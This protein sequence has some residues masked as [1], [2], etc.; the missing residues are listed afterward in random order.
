MIDRTQILL[1][2]IEIS[3]EALSQIQLMIEHDVTIENK[4]LRLQISGKGC[5]GFDYSMGFIDRL[6]DDL[7]VETHGL[8]FHFD[9]FSAYYMSQVRLEYFRDEGDAEGFVITN[10][11]QDKFQ[12]KFWRKAPDLLPPEAP[13]V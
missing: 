12:G 6:P 10:L 2:V 13:K 7:L 5:H 11:T 9:P 8:V 3:P 1:P 4:V